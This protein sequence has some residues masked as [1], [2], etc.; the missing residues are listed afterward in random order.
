MVEIK[1][2]KYPPPQGITRE[3]MLLAGILHSPKASLAVQKG[4]TDMSLCALFILFFDLPKTK[5]RTFFLKMKAFAK[6]M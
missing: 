6:K 3:S 1:C 4:L 2:A 5:I